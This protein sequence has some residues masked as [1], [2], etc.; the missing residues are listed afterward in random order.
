MNLSVFVQGGVVEGNVGLAPAFAPW[1]AVLGEG[2]IEMITRASAFP[3]DRVIVLYEQ[4]YKVHR[5]FLAGFAA[6]F[7]FPAAY[8]GSS[9]TGKTDVAAVPRTARVRAIWS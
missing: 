2:M 7:S 1:L 9:V 8:A 5:E 6:V 4:Y 3:S